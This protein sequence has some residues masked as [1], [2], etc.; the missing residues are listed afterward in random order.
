MSRLLVYHARALSVSPR[1]LIRRSL[2]L[3]RCH[4]LARSQGSCALRL[5][6][7]EQRCR[8]RGAIVV[9]AIVPYAA[10]CIM[11]FRRARAASYYLVRRYTAAVHQYCLWLN[12]AWEL[13][14]IA[15]P[16]QL[17]AAMQPCIL[18]NATPEPMLKRVC[19]S[20]T[21]C[22]ELGATPELQRSEA[23]CSLR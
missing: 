10:V 16:Q 5:W 8:C 4:T 20:W 12:V 6:T 11:V 17:E 3:M 9:T 23:K 22:C 13:V 14:R 19:C 1:V 2:A 15:L 18:C 21:T 7:H